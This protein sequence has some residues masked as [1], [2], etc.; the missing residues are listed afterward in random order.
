ME[1]MT[2]DMMQELAAGLAPWARS[3]YIRAVGDGYR[4]P[5]AGIHINLKSTDGDGAFTGSGPVRAIDLARL[6]LAPKESA[7]LE[8]A[9]G[10]GQEGHFP[11]LVVINEDPPPH[12]TWL[13]L[14][15]PL[16]HEGGANPD[17]D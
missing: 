4:R 9:M 5:C 13:P 11:F 14:D 17:Q 16:Q 1:A 7:E 15:G 2:E 8:E 6:E 3:A 12:L 10:Q